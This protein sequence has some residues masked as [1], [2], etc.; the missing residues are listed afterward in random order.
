MLSLLAL[1]LWTPTAPAPPDSLVYVDITAHQGGDCAESADVTRPCR[2]RTPWSQTELRARW[3]AE[4]APAWTDGD[5]LT[6]VYEGD[7]EGVDACCAIQMPMSRF[8]GSDLWVLSA[9]IPELTFATV[10][11]GFV[12]A[13]ARRLEHQGTLRGT[14]AP[15]EPPRARALRGTVQT[16]S[17]WSAALTE[18][19]AVTVYL[20]PGHDASRLSPVV[21][22]ADGQVVN[23]LAEY[24]EPFIM[25]GE[26]PPTVLVGIHSGPFRGEEYTS[27]SEETNEPDSTNARF[28]AHERFVFDEVIP[29]AERTFGASTKR[30]ERAAFGFSNGGVWASFQGVRHPNVFGVAVPF[31]CGVCVVSVPEEPVPAASGAAAR[32]YFQAGRLESSFLASTRAAADRLRAAGYEAVM[33]ERV[34]GHDSVMWN[35]QFADAVRWAFGTFATDAP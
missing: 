18:R 16:D 19:R 34:A 17:L 1:L 25:A 8:A 32:F 26:V 22:V 4:G 28:L 33:H 24:L 12:P 5:T 30:E 27:I 11:Y 35:E 20:P 15:T 29:W 3:A 10:G 7:T 21:Y 14:S 9:R 6:L 31:S 2:A 13:G 23:T